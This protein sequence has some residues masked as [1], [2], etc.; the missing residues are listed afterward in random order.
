VQLQN[1]HRSITNDVKAQARSKFQQMVNANMTPHRTSG[2]WYE[3]V[4]ENPEWLVIYAGEHRDENGKL[5]QDGFTVI[6]V[7]LS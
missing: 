1:L 6:I 3:D 2:I 5:W 4:D 7:I